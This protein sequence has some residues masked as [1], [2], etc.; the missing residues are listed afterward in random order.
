MV[1]ADLWV[2]VLLSP[3]TFA[4]CP[5]VRWLFASR[6]DAAHERRRRFNFTKETCD[7]PPGAD[8]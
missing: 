3:T 1:K 5:S 4:A 7:V 2:I 6:F 8:D